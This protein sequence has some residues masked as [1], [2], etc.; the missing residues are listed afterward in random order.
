[1]G[2]L[3]MITDGAVLARDAAYVGWLPTEGGWEPLRPD[4]AVPLWTDDYSNLLGAMRS[5]AP[6]RGA[7]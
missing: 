2:R 4:P 1:M 3:G 5:M 7:K 6:T